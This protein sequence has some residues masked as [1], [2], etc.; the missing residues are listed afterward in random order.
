MAEKNV[1]KEGIDLYNKR[2]YAASLAFFLSLPD[3]TNADNIDLAYYIGLCYAK[4]Q[5]YE[6]ALDYLEQVVTSGANIDRILQCRYVLAVIYAM[7][8][9]KKLA[10]FELNKLLETGYKP[11]MVYAS[12]AYIS[13]EQADVDKCIEYYKKALE[14]D[15]ENPTALNGMGY[16]LACENRDLTMALSYCKKA[17]NLSPNSAACLD[18]VGWVYLKLGLVNDALKYLYQARELMPENYDIAEHIKL[19]QSN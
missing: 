11:S 16:V 17:L 5:R 10:Q 19:A 6:D 18:S 1:L 7:S 8:N 9:R 14:I 3:D 15:S 12:L 2:D 4:L 13:W